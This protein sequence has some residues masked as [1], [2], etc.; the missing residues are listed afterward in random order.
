[1]SA[2]LEAIKQEVLKLAPEDLRQLREAI[3]AQLEQT[4]PP[5]TE[6]EFEEMLEKRGIITRAKN[7]NMVSEFR[8]VEVKGKP[9]SETI[10]EERR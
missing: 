1:M 7:R 9:V 5:M 6:D 2:N 10:I 8:P 3:D 4:K